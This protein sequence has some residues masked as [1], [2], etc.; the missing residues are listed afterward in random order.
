LPLAARQRCRPAACRRYAW[1]QLRGSRAVSVIRFPFERTIGLIPN[2]A[3]IEWLYRALDGHP[4]VRKKRLIL[5]ACRPEVNFLDR[6]QGTVLI[7]ALGL[8]RF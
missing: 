3:R 5:E 6:Q 4:N 7:D 8:A 2:D 1:R